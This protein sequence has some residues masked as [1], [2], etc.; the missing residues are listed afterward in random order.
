MQPSERMSWKV[1]VE[2]LSISSTAYKYKARESR[3]AG[4]TCPTVQSPGLLPPRLRHPTGLALASG[5]P[6]QGT[7]RRKTGGSKGS[8]TMERRGSDCGPLPSSVPCWCA[9][10]SKRP[11]QSW[12]PEPAS[13]LPF[14]LPPAPASPL[15]CVAIPRPSSAR[16]RPSRGG[17]TEQPGMAGTGLPWLKRKSHR[18]PPLCPLRQAQNSST[19]SRKSCCENS[20]SNT[21][22]TDCTEQKAF[23][24]FS[25]ITKQDG[26]SS[27]QL[28]LAELCGQ[29]P[30]RASVVPE[31][32]K[33]HQP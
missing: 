33:G 19:N 27:S 31:L 8:R 18:L 7:E 25:R 20:S 13:V 32:F 28:L 12:L 23:W 4:S 17:T 22:V 14:L 5:I 30:E 10:M 15:P 3:L 1:K 16:P 9:D 26:R 2:S 29:T 24:N 6:G 11:Q 21:S